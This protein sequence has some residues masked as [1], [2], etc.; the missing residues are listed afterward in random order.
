MQQDELGN[1]V[2]W[3]GE[4]SDKEKENQFRKETWSG[5]TDRLGKVVL[6]TAGFFLIAG[7]LEF[8]NNNDWNI[9]LLSV[10]VLVSFW[11]VF[12][13]ISK[14][15]EKLKKY[16]VPFISVYILFLG[17]IE[18]YG[19]VLNYTPGIE[20][21]IPFTLLIILLIYLLFPLAIKGVAPASI[22]SSLIYL[23]VLRFLYKC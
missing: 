21:G 20:M 2:N 10:R 3:Y 5:L 8:F 14:S 6:I 7:L 11:A 23:F 18:S 16:L 17:I 19:A 9:L 15:N 1:Q 22:V 4:F 13:F 12:L